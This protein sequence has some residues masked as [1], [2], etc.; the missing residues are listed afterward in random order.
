MFICEMIKQLMKQL[1]MDT[2]LYIKKNENSCLAISQ[3]CN[4]NP[5]QSAA[6][7][8]FFF[9][10][11]HTQ[12]RHV[13]FNDLLLFSPSILLALDIFIWNISV[14]FCIRRMPLW[15]TG[16]YEKKWLRKSERYTESVEPALWKLTAAGCWW[17]VNVGPPPPLAV[18]QRWV[19]DY[20]K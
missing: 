1:W 6:E 3:F 4:Y 19:W 12:G 11:T 16:T 14:A 8:R 17:L 2:H 18:C 5:S 13:W 9:G 7:C 20:I 10:S 15:F